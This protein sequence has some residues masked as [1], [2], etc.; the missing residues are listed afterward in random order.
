MIK[1]ILASH[2][3]RMQKSIEALKREFATLR[4]GRATPSLLDKVT[5]DYY[6]A[7]T[8]VNQIA[9]VSV[10]EPRMII[11]QPYEKSILHD[12]EVAIMK[13]DLGLSPNSDGTAI[14]LAI[15]ALTQ[16]RRQELVKTVNKKAE[17]AKVAI[18]NV[19]RDGNDAI[20]KLEK[21]KEI[22]E[23]DSKRGQESMQKLVDKYIKLVDTTKDAKE[24]EVMEV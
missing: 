4:A 11:I 20:K 6:G 1:D 21:A 14:R 5:V 24:K 10:P 9:K 8:P 15:P 2:E 19:R 7:P 18:R 16:E 23:D 17:E 13:S 22:T 3:E 12:I